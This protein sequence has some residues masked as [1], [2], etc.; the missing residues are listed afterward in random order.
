LSGLDLR[1][2]RPVTRIL[3]CA[4]L[5]SRLCLCILSYPKPV[6]QYA[7]SPDIEACVTWTCCIEIIVIAEIPVYE[8]VVSSVSVTSV[9]VKIVAVSKYPVVFPYSVGI[10]PCP[11]LR[12]KPSACIVFKVEAPVLIAV[13]AEPKDVMALL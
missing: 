11:I 2:H 1:P 7:A 9:A 3:L 5:N 12:P 4:D 8:L 10:A 6:K 13:I